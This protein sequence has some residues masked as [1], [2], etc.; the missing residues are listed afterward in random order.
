MIIWPPKASSLHK[1]SH[2]PEFKSFTVSPSLL[3]CLIIL[4]Q[5][6]YSGADR[7]LV[8]SKL[9]VDKETQ[10]KITNTPKPCYIVFILYLVFYYG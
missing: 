10:L 7:L 6:F 3:S 1:G 5:V 2:I 9:S 8:R 4:Y